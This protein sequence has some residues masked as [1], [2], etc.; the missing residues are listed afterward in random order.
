[1]FWRD[2][3]ILTDRGWV[4]NTGAMGRGLV[5]V[6]T[7]VGEVGEDRVGIWWGNG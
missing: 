4:G 2:Q 5:V 3:L 6:E 7:G 1:M